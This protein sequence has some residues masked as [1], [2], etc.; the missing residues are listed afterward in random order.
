VIEILLAAFLSKIVKNSQTKES[1]FLNKT[2]FFFFSGSDLIDFSIK[3]FDFKSLY[4]L[5]KNYFF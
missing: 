2:L 4:H 1:F 5:N 3:I